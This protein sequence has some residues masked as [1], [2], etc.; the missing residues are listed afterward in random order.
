MRLEPLEKPP[1]LVLRIAY[2]ISRRR[3]GRVISPLSVIYARVPYLARIGNALAMAA[4]KKTV[5]DPG[6]RLLIQAQTSA[7]NGCGFCLDIKHAEAVRHE[8]GLERFHALP[9]YETSPLFSEPERAALRYAAEVTARKRVDDATFEALRE[10]FSER[11][12]VE[13]TFVNAL[14]NFHNSLAVPLGLESDGLCAIAQRR[15][16]A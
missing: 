6:L 16:A 12:I 4:E 11:E 15:A 7:H 8:L 13:I 5:L 9:E 3:F 1:T 10:H 2:W 14:E